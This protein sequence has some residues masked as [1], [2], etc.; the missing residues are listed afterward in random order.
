[1]IAAQMT[2]R[3]DSMAHPRLTTSLGTEID[4][5][6]STKTLPPVASGR[7]GVPVAGGSI[8]G[9]CGPRDQAVD[10]VEPHREHDAVDQDEQHKSRGYRVS[11]ERRDRVGGAQLLIGDPGL[12]SRR[13]RRRS[14]ATRP[15]KRKTHNPLK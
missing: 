5:P 6:V 3:Y 9:P 12:P 4:Y 1:M 8:A 14:R 15:S 11:G 13:S 10:V 2:G 7:A